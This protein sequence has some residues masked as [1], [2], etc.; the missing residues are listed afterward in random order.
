M[1]FLVDAQLPQRLARDLA[2]AGHDVVHTLDLP[3]GNR[4]R[5]GEI[6]EIAA[7]EN[8]VVITKDSDFVTMFLLQGLPPR[9]LLIST[10]NISN[11]ALA[12]LMAANL[13]VLEKAF[14]SHVF[15]ELS[16]SAILFHA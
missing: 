10:G 15:V 7:R 8:R 9:L 1:K 6:A 4:T 11:D 12:G 14:V 13:P 3:H 16:A 5:D 2:A